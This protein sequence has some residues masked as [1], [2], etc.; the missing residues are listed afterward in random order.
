MRSKIER[1]DKWHKTRNGRL[2][3]GIFELALA[4]VTTSVAIDNGSLLLYVVTIGLLI[5]SAANTIESIKLSRKHH[6]RKAQK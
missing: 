5:G 6:D 1:L 2:A 3:F 4:Y